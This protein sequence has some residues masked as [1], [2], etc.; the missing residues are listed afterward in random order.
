MYLKAHIFYNVLMALLGNTQIPDIQH[1]ILR[2]CGLLLHVEIDLSA[3]HHLRHFF[4]ACILYVNGSDIFPLAQDT[5][6]IG[7]RLD[8][9]QLMCDKQN[10]F[11]F[12]CQILHDPHQLIDFLR[13]QHRRR[14]IKNQNFVVTVQ[15]FQYFH[16][17]LHTDG[18]LTG[19]G[20]HIDIQ[21]ILLTQIDNLFSCFDHR[22]QSVLYILCTQNDVFQH[23]EIMNQLKMLM[24]HSDAKT[25]GVIG[26]IDTDNLPIHFDTSLFRLIHTEQNAHE[27]GFAGPIF[28][29][30]GVNLAFFQLQCNIIIG[31]NAREFFCDIT[32]FN[33]VFHG[34]TP[35]ICLLSIVKIV[36]VL[37]PH[38]C[39]RLFHYT[40]F[41]LL[42]Y[43][44]I[45]FF[46]PV[47]KQEDEKN[48][49]AEVKS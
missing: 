32:H 38:L 34:F 18:N 48:Q 9:I 23:C 24:H 45:P 44:I 11:T 5:A 35:I 21:M 27:G 31:N 25:V 15:H 36:S 40:L 33:D 16:T 43:F 22:Q 10:R 47:R 14:L 13:C 20:I 39:V 46:L 17:L 3:N 12:R 37:I 2:L 7:D 6:A 28:A 41:K 4:L 30:Q 49:K 42:S 29:H 19:D 1:D 8:F 26:I